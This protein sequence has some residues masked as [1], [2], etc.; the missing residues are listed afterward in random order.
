[1]S[2][3]Y[4]SLGDPQR[5][6]LIQVPWGVSHLT[7]EWDI[8]GYRIWDEG[9]ARSFSLVKYDARNSGLSGRDR[10]SLSAETYTSDL[11]VVATA[12]GLDRYALCGPA[13]AAKPMI[14]H[15]ARHPDR[16]SHLVLLGP[17]LGS[18]ALPTNPIT[19]INPAGWDGLRR[20]MAFGM[21]G[22][23]RPDLVDQL[24][25]LLGLP[26]DYQSFVDVVGPWDV[27]DQLSDL[28]ALTL[29]VGIDGVRYSPL[30]IAQTVAAEVPDARLVVFE[31]TTMPPFWAAQERE[32][33]IRLIEEHV[34]GSDVEPADGTN[35]PPL[36]GA[37]SFVPADSLS[38]REVEVLRLVA[39]GRTNA[40]IAE[41]LVIASGTAAR[42][43][44][45]ILNKT[46]LSNRTE[47]A[48]YAAAR[49]LI[50]S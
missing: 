30:S 5:P 19:T 36:V 9:L 12:A 44:S 48:A 11:E 10:D 17:Q 47:L 26:E 49:G 38:E 1:M 41:E 21:S 16:V 4:A 3:A 35:A 33:L 7:R 23:T 45:N 8:D 13:A 39:A 20:M 28:K 6:P 25:D 40:Q 27:T 18:E 31:T 43:V 2:L 29:V 34:L 32:A 50:D 15:A 46:G 37:A 14:E 42:H 22:F 24:A